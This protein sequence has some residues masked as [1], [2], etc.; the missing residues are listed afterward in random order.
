MKELNFL[1]GKQVFTYGF[2][3]YHELQDK[4]GLGGGKHHGQREDAHIEL[5][6][7]NRADPF[8]VKSSS[9]RLELFRHNP[10]C[11]SCH[12]VG[13]IWML[14]AHHKNDRPHLNLYHVED[15]MTI[16]E[17]K[18]IAGTYW[19]SVV[20]GAAMMTKDHIRPVSKGGQT[21]WNNLA[22]MCCICNNA[23]GSDMPTNL[24]FNIKE[25]NSSL[26]L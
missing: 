4:V 7:P 10:K 21:T 12:R 8:I 5:H 3:F 22:T 9:Y 13:N 6:V 2:W 18:A 23:K 19:R 17:A 11:I 1:K 26:K 20:D 16:E 25:L 24:A 15:K 14:Q